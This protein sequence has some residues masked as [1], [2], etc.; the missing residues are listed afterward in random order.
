MGLNLS[1]LL[2]KYN[3]FLSNGI[4]FIIFY[5]L[6][7]NF[8]FSNSKKKIFNNTLRKILQKKILKIFKKSLKNFKKDIIL[9]IFYLI[10]YIVLVYF[11]SFLSSLLRKLFF[12]KIIFFLTTYFIKNYDFNNSFNKIW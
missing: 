1:I 8:F 9:N 12:N 5:F 7:K 6:I 3:N 11:L 4:F 10:S 2:L